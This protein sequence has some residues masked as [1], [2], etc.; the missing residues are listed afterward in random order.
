[1]HPEGCSP[2][3]L[4]DVVFGSA[5]RQGAAHWAGGR[6]CEC[7]WLPGKRRAVARPIPDVSRR[8]IVLRN[9]SGL[10]VLLPAPLRSHV[11]ADPDAPPTGTFPADLDEVDRRRGRVFPRAG[12]FS[13]VAV[14][15]RASVSRLT[16]RGRPRSAG[17]ARC[18]QTAR[19][20]D[21]L[22]GE[23]TSRRRSARSPRHRLR[24]DSLAEEAEFLSAINDRAAAHVHPSRR[25][26][27]VST[28]RIEHCDE[29]ISLT[30]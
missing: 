24:A 11:L 17:R 13:Q 21:M 20:T 9:E 29:F 28:G 16:S 15:E 27:K 18:L 25:L 3:N 14:I 26:R 22:A 6:A 19:A 2:C 30:M 23:P 1:M 7:R 8:G 5:P 4:N 12:P 10:G